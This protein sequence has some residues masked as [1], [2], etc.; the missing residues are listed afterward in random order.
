MHGNNFKLLIISFFTLILSGFLLWQ[1]F[2]PQLTELE[3]KTEDKILGKSVSPEQVQG[4][5]IARVTR[6]ID[7][8]TIEI[9]IRGETKKLRYIG[10]NTPETVDPRRPDECFGEE[11]SKENKRLVEGKD[12]ILEK[13]ISETDQ[14]NRLLRY[15]YLPL[16]DGSLLFINDYLVRQG[17]ANASTFPPD[18]KY[19]QQFL[20]AQQEA[21]DNNRGLWGKCQ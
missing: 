9:N 5:E 8:D 11:A 21:R 1:G 19:Y 18:V 14:F 12:I 20:E 13:D 4:K 10:V 2:N 15:I 16:S 3:P 6:V 7:G 17:F